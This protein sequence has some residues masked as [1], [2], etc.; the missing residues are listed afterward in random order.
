[1]QV[2]WCSSLGWAALD[3]YAI[4]HSL[5]KTTVAVCLLHW[6]YRSQRES[7]GSE[8]GKYNR[9]RNWSKAWQRKY[10]ERFQELSGHGQSKASL[11]RSPEGKTD[12]GK[13][14]QGGNDLWSARPTLAP[15][16]GRSWVDC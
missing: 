7:T 3:W 15:F 9:Y 11:H 14:R 1:M 8:T 2:D 4:I 16:R 10:A 5:A 6:P 13:K 12:G